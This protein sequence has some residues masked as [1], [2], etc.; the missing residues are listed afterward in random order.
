MPGSGRHSGPRG[1]SRWSCL[2][3]P[4]LPERGLRGCVARLH[5]GPQ[6]GRDPAQKPAVDAVHVGSGQPLSP[7]GSAHWGPLKQA[8]ALPGVSEGRERQLAGSQHGGVTGPSC[9][10]APAA[11]SGRQRWRGLGPCAVVLNL[12]PA[13]EVSCVSGG[14]R[15]AVSF[16]SWLCDLALCLS[17]PIC[18]MGKRH[19]D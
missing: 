4:V 5:R 2:L 13:L 1:G 18:E 8:A 6:G 14:A 15:I 10:P 9:T 3:G 16:T 11:F 17:F 19:P 7:P 12:P